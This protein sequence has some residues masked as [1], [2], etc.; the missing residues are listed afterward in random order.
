MYGKS[1][2]PFGCY[3]ANFPFKTSHLGKWPLWYL[4]CLLRSFPDKR[5][6]G[7]VNIHNVLTAVTFDLSCFFAPF[8][9][10]GR[11]KQ[12]KPFWKML[13]TEYL[14]FWRVEHQSKVLYIDFSICVFSLQLSDFALCLVCFPLTVFLLKCLWVFHLSRLQRTQSHFVFYK[15][16][17]MFWWCS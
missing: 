7:T 10:K 9:T 5:N 17:S 6:K 16:L 12:N 3:T 1:D 2:F 15:G 13:L 14:S 8:P 4:R 11:N